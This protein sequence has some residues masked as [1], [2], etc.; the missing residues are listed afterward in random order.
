M[1]ITYHSGERIQ[2]LSTDRTSSSTSTSTYFNDTTSRSFTGG[3]NGTWTAKI[4]PVSLTGIPSSSAYKV[5]FKMVVDAFTLDG[6][7]S[8]PRECEGRTGFSSNTTWNGGSGSF[9]GIRTETVQ[10]QGAGLFF[11]A[12]DS[13]GNG[14]A[15]ITSGAISG[16][17]YFECENPNTGSVT[18]KMFDSTYTTQTG[19]TYTIAK[20]PQDLVYFLSEHHN[21]YS[22]QS[23]GSASLTTQNL[24]ALGDVTTITDITPTNVQD[25]SIFVETDTARR[26]WF[27]EDKLS[28]TG[29]KAYYNFDSIGGGTTLTNQATTGDGL[30]SSADGVNTS[31]TLDTTNEKLGTG[32]YSLNG[33]SSKVVLGSASDWNFLSSA[34]ANTWS[35]AWWMK[36]DDTLENGHTIMSTTDGST[37][38][39]GMFIDNSGS[40]D[41]RLIQVDG[42]NGSWSSAIPD[43]TSWH[44]YV[45]TWNAGTVTL[46][47]DGVSKGTQSQTAGS[48]TPQYG[49]NLGVNN[50]EYWTALTLDDMS[51][52][53]RVLTS[54]EISLLYNSGTG[55]TIPAKGATWTMQPTMSNGV[56]G[57]SSGWVTHANSD[58]TLDTTNKGVTYTNVTENAG[59]GRALPV[60]ASNDKWLCQFEF[61]MSAWTSNDTNV[62]SLTSDHTVGFKDTGIKTITFMPQGASYW[63]FV[64]LSGQTNS[65]A[66][67]TA[68]TFA[69]N[70]TYYV[71]MI[72]DGTVVRAKVW[73]N[74]ERT[75]TPHATL[76]DLTIGT[77][78]DG[79]TG[80]QHWSETASDAGSGWV[81]N[82]NFYNG[83]TSIT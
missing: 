5:R 8:Q 69:L 80:I 54:S 55:S 60:T 57:S 82:V 38:T 3:G 20:N 15:Q 24:K 6:G 68:T 11:W 25:N 78:C 56:Y 18:L 22:G 83:V 41:M 27:D 37:Q 14:S 75:G 76:A 62:L 10:W 32:C 46:Y 81:R 2:G 26:Y 64:L 77:N 28:T 58:I 72:R 16:T 47:V 48:G 59:I 70:T 61:N 12:R 73:T 29:L 13:T 65:Y 43:N 53:S 36:Y 63:R 34:T 7:G 45:L 23:L 39:D 40:G 1:A 30:G 79:M 9:L 74:A 66:E 71:D 19:S 33:S 67:T 50:D 52:W 42:N 44:H 35:I 31:V 49:L 4:S 51:I 17:Y 21:N